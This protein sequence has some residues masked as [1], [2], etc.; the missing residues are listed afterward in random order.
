[1]GMY[2]VSKAARDAYLRVLA[3]ENPSMR[4]LSYAPGP[5]D[6]QMIHDLIANVADDGTR[7]VFVGSLAV[8]VFDD[9]IAQTT[10]IV[11]RFSRH[12]SRPTS[13]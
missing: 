9:F 2:A 13:W 8:Y 1:M 3:S 5:I 10:E 7:A 12:N 11:A 6:T 4:V